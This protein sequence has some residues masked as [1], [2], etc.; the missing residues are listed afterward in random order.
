[1]AARLAA[2]LHSAFRPQH[3]AVLV[4]APQVL[5]CSSPPRRLLPCWILKPRMGPAEAGDG[6][7]HRERR[8]RDF[9]D[10]PSVSASERATS[11]HQQCCRASLLAASLIS[12]VKCIGLHLSPYQQPWD[13]QRKQMH[14]DHQRSPQRNTP[15]FCQARGDDPQTAEL[16]DPGVTRGREPFWRRQHLQQCG[17]QY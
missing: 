3:W 4:V 2:L 17:V 6:G 9:P 15:G 7:H 16:G 13:Q 8:T 1:M 14:G 5:S 10:I 12:W 11:C